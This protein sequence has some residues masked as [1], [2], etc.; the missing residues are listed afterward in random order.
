MLEV[1]LTSSPSLVCSLSVFVCR[2]FSDGTERK[3][4]VSFAGPPPPVSLSLFLRNVIDHESST[5]KCALAP[6]GEKIVDWFVSDFNWKVSS[7][8][9]CTCLEQL[10]MGAACLAAAQ[11]RPVEL[12]C[13]PRPQLQHHEVTRLFCLHCPSVYSSAPSSLSL[14]PPSCH[15]VASCLCH[16]GNPV[17]VMSSPCCWR[18]ACQFLCAVTM[19]IV[20]SEVIFNV[21]S[22]G[23]SLYS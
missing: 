10:V 16:H 4:F 3:S 19:A 6:Q 14:S 22:K 11:L 2:V 23:S 21:S 15:V 1:K 5:Q 9:A 18:V 13:F 17:A 7:G 8:L 20:F 12:I